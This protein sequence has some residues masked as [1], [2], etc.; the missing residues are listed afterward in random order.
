MKTKRRL[1]GQLRGA[2]Y[3][4]YSADTIT[5]PNKLAVANIVLI[6]AV[7][8]TNVYPLMERFWVEKGSIV[9]E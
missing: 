3:A 5:T 6:I 1:S 2:S 9:Y 7:D 8:A 4:G